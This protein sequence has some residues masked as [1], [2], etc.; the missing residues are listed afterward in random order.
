MIA[1]SPGCPGTDGGRLVAEQRKRKQVVTIDDVAKAAGVS[2]MTVSRVM[3]GFSGV[4][5]TTREAVMKAVEELGYSPN[6]AARSLARHGSGRVGL[7]YSNPSAGYLS[8]FLVGALDGAQAAGALLLIEKCA[9]DPESEKAAIGKLVAGGAGGVI[10]PS[11]HAES[12][13]AQS[14]LKAAGVAAVA[15]STG[16]LRSDASAVRIDDFAAAA[17]M[18]RHL[19][20]LGHRRIGF[21]KGAPNQ[22][23]S[24]ERL[25][26]FETEIRNAEPVA[27]GLIEQGD[28]TYRSGFEA[29]DRLL[30]AH[31]PPTAIFASNDDMAVGVLAAAHRRGLDVPGQLSIAGFDDTSIA[32]TVWPELTTVRQPVSDMAETA[33][34]MLIE[35]IG[36]RRR[37]GDR[38]PAERM[39]PHALIVRD[40]TGPA[41]KGD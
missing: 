31:Q 9:P 17:E 27:S 22:T 24:A 33:V 29:G 14:E 28:F 10:L 21:I 2:P 37:K 40:S 15:V 18:T 16:R 26:G 1:L 35:E 36:A 25:L 41:P 30:S 34:K 5:D 6:I 19:L 8:Q 3:N 7:L 32:T 12:Y 39:L 38:D 11:P 4:K 13:S 23:A 20:E